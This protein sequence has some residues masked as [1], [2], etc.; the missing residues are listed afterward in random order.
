MANLCDVSLIA[1][2]FKTKSNMDAFAQIL[3]NV[4]KEETR[5]RG[6]W[7]PYFDVGIDVNYD[8]NTI[9]GEG[10]CKWSADRLL[11]SYVQKAKADNLNITSLEELSE[12]FGIDI[13]ILAT[14]AGCNVGE[15]FLF[16]NGEMT[17]EE[18]FDYNE[19]E[20]LDSYEAFLEENGDILDE[21]TWNEYFDDGEEWITDGEPEEPFGIIEIREYPPVKDN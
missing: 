15:H 11:D 17:H 7:L 2:G 12:A 21:D 9:L 20:V 14:E 6:K 13:E 4:N 1:R 19:Y 10:W 5:A 3:R 18:Y 8:D 16:E